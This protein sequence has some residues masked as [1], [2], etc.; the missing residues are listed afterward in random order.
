[1]FSTGDPKK[2]TLWLIDTHSLIFQVFHGI[3][4]MTSP[5]GLPINAVFGIA[6]DLMGLRDRKPTYLVCA[7]DRAEPTFRSS[8]FPAYKAH[9][10]EPPADLVG[11]FSLIEELIVAMGIPLLSMAGFEADD[12][13]ATVATSAQERDL[14]CLICTSDK[15][16][17]QLLT[18]KTRLFNLRKGIEFGMSELAA[19]WGIRP[20]QVVE[21]QA[22]VGDSADNVPGVPGIG[23]KTAAKLLQ[24]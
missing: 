15:D 13:I 10:P 7:M 2:E 8:I 5:A 21:L 1:M 4:M 20:D 16:C 18:E 6:R 14:E 24:E 22:L 3:P 19:D 17:R 12:L 9:R 23:Y 11:Q